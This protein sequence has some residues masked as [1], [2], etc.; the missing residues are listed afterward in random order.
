[1]KGGYLSSWRVNNDHAMLTSLI[2]QLLNLNTW[3]HSFT[4]C[5]PTQ[6]WGAASLTH[7]K[8]TLSFLFTPI[9]A[10]QVLPNNFLKCCILLQKSSDN[11]LLMLCK[12]YTNFEAIN[13]SFKLYH[14]KF[15]HLL[16]KHLSS[17]SRESTFQTWVV[18]SSVLK[19]HSGYTEN[20]FL[21]KIQHNK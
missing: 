11:M 4:L 3:W 21:F 15:F 13:N 1:M 17:H 6:S 12:C 16:N 5:V 7:N 18:S 20:T 9:H 19:R 14:L 10:L 2:F 8:S